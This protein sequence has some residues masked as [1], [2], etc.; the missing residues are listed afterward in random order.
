[1]DSTEA[2]AIRYRSFA[3]QQAA[4]SSPTFENWAQYVSHSSELLARLATLPTDKQQ[5]NLVFAAARM[6]GAVPG[7]TDSLK[8]T[9]DHQWRQVRATVLAR[10]TQT[11][12]AARCGALLLG[13][14]QVTGPIALL[15]LGA[16]AGLC[17][18]PDRYSYIFNHDYR[19]DPVTGPSD[20]T[21]PITLRGGLLPPVRMPEVVWRA[22]LDLNPLD[23]A[24]ADNIGWLQALVWPE[25]EERRRRLS[26]AARVAAREKLRIERA[27]LIDGLDEVA[28]KAPRDAT[29]VITHSATLAYLDEQQRRDAVEAIAGTRARHISFEGRG[30]D[31]EVPSIDTSIT[32]DTLFVAALDGTPYAL[33]DGHGSTLSQPPALL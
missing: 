23:P 25:H 9:L 29:L 1:M 26:V 18:I 4:D 16:A 24:D 17:L 14:Q 27:D 11:N 7:D 30:V 5:P 15:E 2:I 10:S 13:L 8:N 33:S 21:I 32:V 28:R 20:L 6:H 22:G 19:L 3:Q 31:P 12:E